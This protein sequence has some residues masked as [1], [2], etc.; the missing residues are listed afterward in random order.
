M[1]IYHLKDLFCG[2]KKKLQSKA[3]QVIAMPH[4]ENI[5]ITKIV[6]WAQEIEEGKVLD[7]LPITEKEILKLPRAYTGNV[8]YTVLGKP[9]DDWVQLKIKER[10]ELRKQEREMQIA[11][12]P[13]IMRIFQA[14]TTISL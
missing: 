8:I 12:D 9:F 10:N 4:Y 6:N 13:E 7:Y 14:S 5:T 11:M 2:S 1:S 3:I